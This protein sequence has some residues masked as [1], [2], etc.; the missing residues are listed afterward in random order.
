MEYLK[1]LANW[2]LVSRMAFIPKKYTR[3]DPDIL[4]RSRL[5]AYN[6]I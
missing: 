4:I 1:T 5:Y 2:G 3:V 6:L